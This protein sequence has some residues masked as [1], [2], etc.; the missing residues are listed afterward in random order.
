MTASVW[1]EVFGDEIPILC[2]GLVR[3]PSPTVVSW[4]SGHAPV[5]DAEAL[6]L[7]VL[8]GAGYLTLCG[9]LAASEGL[10]VWPVQ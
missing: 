2:L 9:C 8:Q 7:A 5:F 4:L 6:A 10:K 1:Q 3:G